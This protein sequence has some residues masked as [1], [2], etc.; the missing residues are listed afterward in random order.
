MSEVVAAAPEAKKSKLPLI[1]IAV[2]V[3]LLGGGGAFLFLTPMGKSL[4]GK[5][6]KTEEKKQEK[7]DIKKVVFTNLPEILI[8]LRNPDGRSSFLK[9]T[10]IVESPSEEIGQKI[11]KIKPMLVDQFQIFL[12]ELDTDDLKGSAGMS[13][14][15]QELIS[16][17]N[18]LLAPDKVSNIL[19]KEFLI[20]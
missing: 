1:I 19:Y 5:G 14:V 7:M 8:N 2:L 18:S 3:L 6:E 17:T 16:R 9:A 20:Q 15:R 4:M 12:R 11:D 13:R 10:F